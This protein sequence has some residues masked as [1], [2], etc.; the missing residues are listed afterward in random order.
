[1]SPKGTKSALIVGFSL[2]KLVF[3]NRCYWP[4]TEATGQLL[5]DLCEHLGRCGH[6]VHVVCGQP[7]SPRADTPFLPHGVEVRNGVSIHRLTHARFPKRVPAGRLLNLVSFT[8]AAQRYLKQTRFQADVFVSET[9]PFLL[10][11]VVAK[12]ARRFNAHFVAYLQDIYPDVAEAIGKAKPGLVT[13][14]IRSRLRNAYQS[15]AKVIVLGSCMRDRLASPPW[16]LD[17]DKIEIIP[18]WADCTAI[19]PIDHK[20]NKL[21]RQWNLNDKFVVMHSGNMGLTQRLDV[22]IDATNHPSWPE[23]A[24]LLLVGDG[25]A[26]QQLQLQSAHPPTDKVSR[27]GASH[28]CDPSSNLHPPSGRVE[29]SEGRAEPQN[30]PPEKLKAISYQLLA[31]NKTTPRVQFLPY[32]PRE[33]LAES[34]SAA[35]LHVISMHENITGCLCPSKLYGIL[36]AGRPILAIAPDQ[37]DLARTVHEQKIG[38]VCEPGNAKRIAESVAKAATSRIAPIGQ[39]ARRLAET[40][41]N[42]SVALTAFEKQITNLNN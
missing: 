29:R 4:D 36:A 32:V 24:V 19:Q 8:H 41:Y 26:K 3:L 37:T 14:Q 18:N 10:P 40:N 39:T 30:Q 22:L 2:S 12:H 31:K 6:D 7:N 15:A 34:L 42:Q 1:M 38:W 16:S 25:A 5:T 21:R 20:D 17:A 33:Q 28:G 27:F 9:D 13:N 23:N 35:D 11:A